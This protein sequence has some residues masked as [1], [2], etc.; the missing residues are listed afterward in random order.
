MLVRKKRASPEEKLLKIIE[1]PKAG[2]YGKGTGKSFYENLISKIKNVNILSA[3]VRFFTVLALVMTSVFIFVLRK[4]NEEL[5]STEERPSL[6]FKGDDGSLEKYIRLISEK[7]PFQVS[8]G[9]DKKQA[10][11]A[12]EMSTTFKL[13]GI[14]SSGYS[15]PQV[16]I[17]ADGQTYTCS[18]GDILSNDIVVEK[19]EKNKVILNNKG[20]KIELQ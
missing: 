18:E 3:F 8:L 19:I 14:L 1:R 13:V 4:P 10:E 17:E 16:F 12:Q 11:V 2:L 15:E 6:S 9:Q 7:N 20:V 5:G